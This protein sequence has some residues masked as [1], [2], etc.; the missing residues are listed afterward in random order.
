MAYK[1][2][3]GGAD[4]AFEET[5]LQSLTLSQL[6][7]PAIF[8]LHGMACVWDPEHSVSDYVYFSSI[9]KLKK[10]GLPLELNPSARHME[11]DETF[12]ALSQEGRVPGSDSL[13]HK[14]TLCP[15]WG[16]FMDLARI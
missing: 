8:F 3:L 5:I 16:Q 9:S 1:D 12:P 13:G 4:E 14:Q 10:P 2:D 15:Q 11:P 7:N 6:G